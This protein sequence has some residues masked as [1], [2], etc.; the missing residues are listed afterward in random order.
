MKRLL[1]I[2]SILMAALLI[3]WGL[4]V[5]AAPSRPPLDS[6]LFLPMSSPLLT[7]FVYLPMVVNEWDGTPVPTPTPTPLPK[8]QGVGHHRQWQV[9]E[10]EWLCPAL[11]M[12]GVSW[13]YDW[14]PYPIQCSGVEAVPMVWDETQ[15]SVTIS[16]TSEYL[17]VFSEPDFESQADMTPAEGAYYYRQ[18]EQLHPEMKLVSPAVWYTDW[19]DDFWDEYEDAYSEEPRMDAVALH[20]YPQLVSYYSTPTGHINI[21]ASKVDAAVDFADEHGIP[22]VWIT[23]F[24]AQ[25]IAYGSLGYTGTIQYM[26]GMIGVFESEP[27]VTR[28]AW[29]GL[30]LTNF[31]YWPSNPELSAL[32][33]TSLV[34]LDHLLTR[35]GKEYEDAYP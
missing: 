10:N 24:C 33:N 15:I 35:L 4:G 29:F 1:V 25:P 13:Y 7:P 28:W 32:Y 14:T 22:E 11:E 3:G 16:G 17:Q 12:S 6:P 18:V 26:D 34:L 5:Y 31:W 21:S 23:E 20:L 27:K 9:G 2:L 19:L 30:D 8:Y